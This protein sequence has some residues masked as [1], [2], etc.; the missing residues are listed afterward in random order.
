MPITRTEFENT[1][2]FAYKGK[3]PYF[4]LIANGEVVFLCNDFNKLFYSRV[5][6]ITNLGFT[7]QRDFFGQKVELRINFA[8]CEKVDQ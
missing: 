5:S 8:D 6:D 3:K 1:V 7:A 2:V 4:F